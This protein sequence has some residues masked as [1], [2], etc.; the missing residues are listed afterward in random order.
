MTFFRMSLIRFFLN[1]QWM[2]DSFYHITETS[3]LNLKKNE[4]RN[5][6]QSSTLWNFCL[7]WRHDVN[8]M[9]SAIYDVMKSY[10][11]RVWDKKIYNGYIT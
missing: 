8:I 5:H 11:T 9:Y 1:S 7:R 10:L 3:E 2:L 6:T 4:R